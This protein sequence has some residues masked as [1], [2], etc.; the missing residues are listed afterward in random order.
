MSD[1][2]VEECSHSAAMQIPVEH[3]TRERILAVVEAALAEHGYYGL[4]MHRIAETVGIQKASL[5]HYFSSKADLCSAVWNPQAD[6]IERWIRA[7]VDADQPPAVQ[8]R[9]L[10]DAFVDL[11]AEYPERTKVLLWRTLGDAPDLRSRFVDAERPLNL[12]ASLVAWCQGHRLRA[13]VDPVALVLSI[14]GVVVFLLAVGDTMS[15]I[16]STRGDDR[17]FEH[18]IK[19]HVAEIVRRALRIGELPRALPHNSM[20]TTA[21]QKGGRI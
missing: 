17:A 21:L 19:N 16:P 12:I 3:R 5:F 1:S 7:T 14:V 4:R 20:G 18:Q 6:E 11:V 13:P 2:A 8:L 10:L 15:P 9:H